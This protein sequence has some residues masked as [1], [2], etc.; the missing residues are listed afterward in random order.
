[1]TEEKEFK[2]LF[3][4]ATFSYEWNRKHKIYYCPISWHNQEFK[5]FGLYHKKSIR[6]ISEIETTIIAGYDSN[7]EKLTVHSKG[8][9]VEQIKRLE[10]ALIELDENHFYYKY[11]ILPENET[12]EIDFRKTSP[13]GVRRYRYKDLRD[14]LTLNDYSDLKGIAEALKK[15]TWE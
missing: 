5:F 10:N 15:V 9:T 3:V 14:Y 1:M 2:L 4:P 11:Y 12:F 6:T 8:H 13:G 7:S